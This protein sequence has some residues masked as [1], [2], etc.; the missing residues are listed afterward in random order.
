MVAGRRWNGVPSGA[1]AQVLA[2]RAQ[3]RGQPGHNHFRRRPAGTHPF[4]Q[5]LDDAVDVARQRVQARDV[6]AVV[7]F[8]HEGHL[9]DQLR[10]A[11]LQAVL[12]ADR[13]RVE[14]DE[15]GARELAFLVAR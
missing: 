2:Q 7:V 14:G 10:Q 9:R 8:G 1:V 12:G 3:L 13:L 15:R 5:L 6:V 4:A 11:D